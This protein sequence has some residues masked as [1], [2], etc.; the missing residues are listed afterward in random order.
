MHARYDMRR[1]QQA[2]L[3]QIIGS[4]R[5]ILN[6]NLKPIS[7][8][9]QTFYF[10]TSFVHNLSDGNFILHESCDPFS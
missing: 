6:E 9:S 10:G 5:L 1:T 7:S 8:Y 2:L 3:F 4:E